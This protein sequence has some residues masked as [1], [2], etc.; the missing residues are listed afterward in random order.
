MCTY[1][2]VAAT[3]TLVS[4]K[5]ISLTAVTVDWRGPSEGVLGGSGV[6]IIHY[7]DG[8]TNR[9]KK[10]AAFPSQYV[11]MDLINGHT[12]AFTVEATS[13]HLSGESENMTITLSES[14]SKMP[15]W[16][17]IKTLCF[18]P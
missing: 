5:Q 10:V 2:S 12:Y 14:E 1:F 4:L 8:I 13:Q 7:S 18:H 16:K 9:N 6:Y 17:P 11:I 3:P 15:G